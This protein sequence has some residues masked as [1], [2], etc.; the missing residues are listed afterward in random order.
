MVVLLVVCAV[1]AVVAVV[2]A[3]AVVFVA[4]VVLAT[5]FVVEYVVVVVDD[6]GFLRFGREGSLVVAEVEIRVV[7]GRDVSKAKGEFAGTVVV[8]VFASKGRL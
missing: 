7:S 4:V 1:V 8:V 2:V 6:V 5:A 3:A